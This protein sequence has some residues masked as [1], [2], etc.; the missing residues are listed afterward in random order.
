MTKTSLNT[1]ISEVENKML[2]ASSLV[3]TTV[4]DTKNQLVKIE[5]PDHAKHITTQ[6]FIKLTAGNFPARLR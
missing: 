1:K 2:N 3:T 6:K 4:F 5:I